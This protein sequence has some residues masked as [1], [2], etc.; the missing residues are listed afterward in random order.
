MGDQGLLGGLVQPLFHHVDNHDG[1]AFGFQSDEQRN[2]GFRGRST[3]FNEP[4]QGLIDPGL[5]RRVGVQLRPS[6]RAAVLQPI[7]TQEDGVRQGFSQTLGQSC[8]AAAQRTDNIIQ[9]PHV[10]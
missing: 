6:R 7:E 10:A 8:F 9:R 4:R 5:E 1:R 2:Q 3:V